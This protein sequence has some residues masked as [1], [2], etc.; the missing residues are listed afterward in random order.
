MLETSSTST[1]STGI[2]IWSTAPNYDRGMN[3]ISF[4]IS[5]QLVLFASIT[6]YYRHQHT[7][8]TYQTGVGWL[9]FRYHGGVKPLLLNTD[10]WPYSPNWLIH[11]F[12]YFFNCPICSLSK[13]NG[14][15]PPIFNWLFHY[16]IYDSFWL[17]WRT[18]TP[19]T[20]QL[21]VCRTVETYDPIKSP[22]HHHSITIIP[23]FF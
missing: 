1:E 2:R 10:H 15:N 18:L 11:V 19:M 9:L 22:L 16:D 4:K 5:L 21:L 12:F 20:H 6:I 3:D 17:I 14:L 7:S 13:G 23:W 8:S